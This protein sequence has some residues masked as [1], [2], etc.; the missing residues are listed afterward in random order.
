MNMPMTSLVTDNITE[1]LVKII[2]FTQSRQKVLI[3]N[4]NNVH[5]CGFVPC[6]LTVNEFADSLNTAIDEHIQN[7]RLIL[8]DSENV[9][10]GGGLE[11]KAIPD[12]Y[13]K[14]LL[15]E[16]RDE[17]LELQINKLLEN[18]FNQKMAAELLRQKER[19][20]SDFEQSEPQPF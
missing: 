17:Y 3:Q 6:D 4:I 19:M 2:E 9:K 16:N 7:Q 8:C 18:S 1:L 20:T 10:F 14:K 12:K 15:E 13:A 5:T 11:L